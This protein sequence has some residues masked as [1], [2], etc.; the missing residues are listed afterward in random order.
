[1]MDTGIDEV[2]SLIEKLLRDRVEETNN[3]TLRNVRLHRIAE[4]VYESLQILHG[5]NNLRLVVEENQIRIY[6]DCYEPI[7]KWNWK[8]FR[9]NT[10]DTIT[11]IHTCMKINIYN[12]IEPNTYAVSYLND[13]EF[14]NNNLIKRVTNVLEVDLI[15]STTITAIK[16]LVEKKF[17]VGKLGD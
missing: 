15:R 12:D 8:E 17:V 9:F 2:N 13:N 14:V 6:Q 7:S 5:H 11:Y 10:V 4:E 16:L 3:N 1:M